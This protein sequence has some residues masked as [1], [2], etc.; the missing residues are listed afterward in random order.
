MIQ[1]IAPHIYSNEYKN[2]P[3]EKNSFV[4]YF[5]DQQ[6]LTVKKQEGETGFPRFQDLDELNDGL[7]E[8]SIYLFSI[9][10]DR[11]YLA[12]DI[13]YPPLAHFEMA[14]TQ[15]FRTMKPL[16]T[17][18]AGITG[19]QLYNW[20]RSRRYCG[21]C[22]RR[23]VPDGKE[24]MMKCPKCGQME[25]PKIC[26]AVI[27]GITHGNRL[28]MSKYA[29]R[30]YKKYA[31]IAGF[32]EVGESIEDTVRREVMEEVGLKVK[33]IRYYKSQPWSFTDTLL[34]GFFCDLDGEEEI[35]LDREELAMAEWFEREDI[36]VTEKNIS[37][38]NEMIIKFKKG[39]E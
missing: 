13:S 30:E 32:N 31:L 34:M 23:M 12:D 35:T 19:F 33:N 38:T 11:F 7:Y 24:R 16:H 29:G 3:P 28:L 27:V 25:Y 22:G 17:A 21:G 15:E 36:P 26:P 1:D 10:E 6:V 20:Y 14:N 5:K 9:D 39:E 8:D 2:I 4:L 18:F 37:L